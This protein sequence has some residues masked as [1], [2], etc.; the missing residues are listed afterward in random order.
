MSVVASLD[1]GSNT[2]RLLVARVECGSRGTIEFTALH[3]ELATPRL[4]RGLLP[5]GRLASSS[6]EAARQGAADFVQRARSLGAET[7]ALAATQ[8]CRLAADGAGFVHDLGRELGLD[9]AVVLSGEQEAGLSRLGVLSRLRGPAANALL[10]DVGGGSTEL[11]FLGQEDGPGVS[12]ALGSVLLAEKHLRHDP[13]RAGDLAALERDIA[14]SLKGIPPE[15][16]AARRLV[17]SAG[18][19][20]TCAAMK[21]GLGEYR[22]ER[23]DNLEITAGELAEQFQRLVSL[24]LAQRWQIIGLEPERADIIPAGIAILRGLLNKLNLKGLTA[25]DA[26]LLEGILLQAVREAI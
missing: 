6:K 11:G 8:A 18:T 1:L 5:G 7:V 3:R 22:P 2:L 9:Q 17:A 16:S 25:M 14:G 10:A 20:A 26:G 23:I 21:L 12:L 24:P 13:P 19:A 15:F 4:G